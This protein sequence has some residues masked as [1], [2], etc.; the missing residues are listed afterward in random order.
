MD[1]N[2]KYL[3]GR[4]YVFIIEFAD[5]KE[6]DDFCRFM[7]ALCDNTCTVSDEYTRVL[8]DVS[9]FVNKI[10]QRGLE[11][12]T[13]DDKPMTYFY[14]N[15]ASSYFLNSTYLLMYQN[16]AYRLAEAARIEEYEKK[17][18]D[19]A[20]KQRLTESIVSDMHSTIVKNDILIKEQADYIKKQLLEFK[21][22]SG[23]ECLQNKLID[24]QAMCIGLF[25]EWHDA[26]REVYIDKREEDKD[27]E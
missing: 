20:K 8:N 3:R 17:L 14:T 15:E 19:A 22:L 11:E 27:K 1:I 2:Y 10:I 6:F 24:S 7:L 18:E 25:K 26:V 9:E 4:R 23:R 12:R 5:E 13:P 16:D 21:E